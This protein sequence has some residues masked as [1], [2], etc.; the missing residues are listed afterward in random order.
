MSDL[1]RLTDEERRK[2]VA[3]HLL[4]EP[5]AT[6]VMEF[7]RALD[8]ARGEVERLRGERDDAWKRLNR[9]SEEARLL[10]HLEVT[11][12]KEHRYA[13]RRLNSIALGGTP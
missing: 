8:E 4:G 12:K 3:A 9:I 10:A 11:E 1:A 5:A 13:A 6:V 2:T 7:A